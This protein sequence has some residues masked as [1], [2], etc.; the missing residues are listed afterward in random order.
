MITVV[1]TDRYDQE[2]NLLPETQW[3]SKILTLDVNATR[4]IWTQKLDSCCKGIE[5][6]ELRKSAAV[7]L[8]NGVSSDV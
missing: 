1:L 2:R 5:I 8:Q 7:I 3:K 6:L 4:C